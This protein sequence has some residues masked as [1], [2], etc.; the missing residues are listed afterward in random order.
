MSKL[1]VRN[2][3]QFYSDFF[4]PILTSHHESSKIYCIELDE[5][6]ARQVQGLIGFNVEMTKRLCMLVIFHAL[7]LFS[8]GDFSQN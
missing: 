8:F 5:R 2:F 4:L 1:M 6:T 7:N 3:S